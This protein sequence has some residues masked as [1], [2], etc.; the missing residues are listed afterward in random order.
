MWRRC[1]I[2]IAPTITS[3]AAATSVGTIEA[4]GPTNMA[5]RNSVPVTM[6]ARPVRAPSSI[7]EP[8]S[9]NTVLEDAEVAPPATAPTPS[10]MRAAGNRGN[11][12]CASASPASRDSPVNVPRASKKFAN[13]RVNTSMVA[14][15]APIRSKLP[16]LNA[17]TSDRSGIANGEPDSFG[18]A[19]VQP[20]GWSTAEPRCQTDSAITAS[21]V[22]VTSPIRIP[23]RT[24]RASRTPVSSRVT[25]KIRVGM[26]VIEP[27][28]PVPSPTGGAGRPVEETN[29]ES[30][31]PMNRMNRPIPAVMAILSCM[32]TAS[33]ISLRRP[34]TASATMTRPL[35]TT[36]PIA[37]G[38]VTVPTT[39]AARNELI[40]SPAAKANG[41]RAMAPKRMVIT[42]AV[43][44]VT[45][46][47][48]PKES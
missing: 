18:T 38:Q 39:E 22:P 26:V 23:P 47:T 2:I 11:V 9:M 15:S 46:E 48:C 10:T 1:D 40:P 35:I 43:R 16:K 45:D 31:S 21:T 20:P 33:K 44:A 25:T 24:R 42:P 8:D 30:T 34:E 37:S 5:A 7:P 41:K 13:T 28:P 19:S 17:P 32:G 12:P 4:S 29:P 6:L 27:L 14:A 3:A 36:R